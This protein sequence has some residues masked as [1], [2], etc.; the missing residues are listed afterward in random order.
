MKT[1]SDNFRESSIIDIARRLRDM[2]VRI[3][4]YEPALKTDSFEGMVVTNDVS[5][6]MNASD[7]IVANR[8]DRNLDAVKD[9]VITRDIFDRD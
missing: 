1:G 4:I 8:L 3:Q 6:F 2:G 5:T 9:K 7:A